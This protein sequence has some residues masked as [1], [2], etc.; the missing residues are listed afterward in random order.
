MQ[1]KMQKHIKVFNK[2]IKICLN[3]LMIKEIQ[4]K[5]TMENKYLPFRDAN[6]EKIAKMYY[7]CILLFIYTLG[8]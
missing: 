3:S 4:L 2:Y 6:N 7:Q 5:I 1:A 8:L